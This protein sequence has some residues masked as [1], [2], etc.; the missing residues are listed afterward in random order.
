MDGRTI[1]RQRLLTLKNPRRF[2]VV[3]TPSPSLQI[4]GYLEL[5]EGENPRLPIRAVECPE[6]PGLKIARVDCALKFHQK[7][8]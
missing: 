8:C 2:A 6:Q 3:G 1:D 5:H 4:V 7:E